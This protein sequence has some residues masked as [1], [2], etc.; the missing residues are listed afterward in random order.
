MPLVSVDYSQLEYKVAATVW[1][2]PGFQEAAASGDAHGGVAD[3]MF[4][5]TDD[6]ILKKERRVLAKNCN[7]GTL[8]GSEGGQILAQLHA[9]GFTDITQAMVDEFIE[10]FHATFPGLFA[11]M[12]ETK[13][14]A[15]NPGYVLTLTGGKR[16]FYLGA[17]SMHPKSSQ[18]KKELREALNTVVQGPSAQLMMFAQI[19]MREWLIEH[20]YR[21]LLV[22]NVHD[23]VMVD[24]PPEEVRGIVA[25]MTQ[26]M[27]TLPTAK[28]PWW[29]PFELAVPLEAEPEV[30]DSWGN[31]LPFDEWQ[32]RNK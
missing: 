11:Y 25:A 28:T 5:P 19:L 14:Q 26:I 20:G 32:E 24:A 13:T 12:E 4:G 31:M 2:D 8:Y 21:A 16:H 15:T 22:N 7:F 30:G 3:V 9:G 18:Y 27:V 6:P 1:P 29:D 10:N 23:A 17:A